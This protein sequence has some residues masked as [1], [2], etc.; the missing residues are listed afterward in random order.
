MTAQPARH[1]FT[2]HDYYR[3]ARAGILHEDDRVELIEGEVI[4]MPPIGSHHTA[5]VERL[6]WLFSQKLDLTQT[7]IRV[8]DPV[9]LSPDTEPQP[10]IALV[11]FR[12]D[13]YR[14]RHPGPDELLLVIEVADSSLA[15]DQDIKVP[16][17]ARSGVP[18]IWVVDVAS[19]AVD[20]FRQ[21]Q[22]NGYSDHRRVE[23]SGAWLSPV[24]LPSLSIQLQDIVGV[25]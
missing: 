6:N 24:K 9:R 23:D 11:P 18:E 16:L 22:A 21:P 10:D 20:I 4:E 12:E 8:Q 15:Y 7:L 2:V 13:F 19:S 14:L 1:H 25:R 17:Y 5:I 3:M